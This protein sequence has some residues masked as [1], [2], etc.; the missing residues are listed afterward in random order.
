M[1]SSTFS[2]S[3]ARLTRYCTFSCLSSPCS[4]C[5]SSVPLAWPSQRLPGCPP[6]SW[7]SIPR[8]LPLQFAQPWRAL[9]R[10]VQGTA[11]VAPVRRVWPGRCADLSCCQPRWLA[12]SGRSGAPRGSTFLECSL[13]CRD[14]LWKSTWGW[15]GCL[16]TTGVGG[17]RSPLDLQCPTKPAL[18]KDR[19]ARYV[20]T[21]LCA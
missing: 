7:Q 13:G 14:C 16:G 1:E 2:V 6:W 11:S 17:G 12:R 9:P 4:S 15:C 18:P 21:I 5:S 20:T 19:I 10:N 3:C 8:T